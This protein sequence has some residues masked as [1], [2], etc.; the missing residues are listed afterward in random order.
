MNALNTHLV[1]ITPLKALFQTTSPLRHLPLRQS[2]LI[3]FNADIYF[4]FMRND[5]L[6]RHDAFAQILIRIE[7]HSL[8]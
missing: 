3:V 6:I 8:A 2:Y 5:A 4:C 7:V 1:Y